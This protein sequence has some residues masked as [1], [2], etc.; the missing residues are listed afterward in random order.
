MNTETLCLLRATVTKID[1][2]CADGH[3]LE[4]ACKQVEATP[5]SYRR[6]KEL[7]AFSR[8][9]DLAARFDNI[10]SILPDLEAE[11]GRIKFAAGEA[12][13]HLGDYADHMY[14]VANGTVLVVELEATVHAGEVVGEIGVFSEA[15][16]RTASAVCI[17]DCELVRVPRDRAL[18]I[19][20]RKPGIGLAMTQLIADRLTQNMAQNLTRH[21]AHTTE[22]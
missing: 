8:L 16:R 7:L 17:E 15:H 6:W 5:R 19:S 4:N 3:S 9:D 20:C 18:E 21:I 1:G 22:L 11:F 14:V 10:A 2:L 12:L 13:F